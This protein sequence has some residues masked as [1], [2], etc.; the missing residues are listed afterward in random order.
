MSASRAF[1]TCED[2]SLTGLV[3]E[4]PP[5]RMGHCLEPVVR[6]QLAIDVMQMVPQR[7]RGNVELGRNCG[8]ITAFC[9]KRKYAAFLVG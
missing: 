3:D 5:S 1:R 4:S 8:G 6:P 9:E 7:L 2:Q